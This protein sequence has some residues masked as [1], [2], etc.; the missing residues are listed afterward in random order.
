MRCLLSPRARGAFRVHMDTEWATVE[1]RS[2]NRN[3]LP[4]GSFK[5][6]LS[7]MCFDS[8]HRLKHARRNVPILNAR[9]RRII[10][11]ILH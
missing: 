7:D 9:L 5:T 1:L 11:R 10:S 2:S 8:R 3:K 6:G 4:Q